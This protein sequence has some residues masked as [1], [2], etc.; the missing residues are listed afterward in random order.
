MK[1][2]TQRLLFICTYLLFATGTTFAADIRLATDKADFGVGEEFVVSVLISSSDSLNAVEGKVVFNTNS[3]S[4]RDIRAGSSAVNFWVDKPEAVQNGEIP[5][6]GITP[7][8]FSGTNKQ[9]FSF[10][11][12]P[13]SPG[14]HQIDLND[15][16]VLRN[17]GSGTSILAEIHGL[18]VSINPEQKKILES[19][20]VD[21]EKP[22]QFW[23]SIAQDPN[24]FEGKY[25]L[26]FATQD[27]ISGIAKYQVKEGAF[28][29]FIDAQSPYLLK[30]Q[31][32]SK[33]IIVRAIDKSGNE[34]LATLN[35]VHQPWYLNY[36]VIGI[37]LTLISL[38]FFRSIKNT[39]LHFIK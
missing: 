19:G 5:F 11:L 30:D 36:I 9:L 3:F 18:S 35:S 14:A 27:K 7:G 34:R 33:K 17:D 16:K 20:P 32:L 12:E 10:V 13:R 38:L 8:G 31:N 29:R 23:L 1:T 2:Y 4:V 37:S 24:I 28:G 26:V 6:S 15:V 39:W 21:N 25:F 22:E